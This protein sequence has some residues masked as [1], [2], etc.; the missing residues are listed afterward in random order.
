VREGPP[1]GSGRDTWAVSATESSV[2]RIDAH[3][4]LWPREV[5]DAMERRAEPPYVRDGVMHVSGRPPYRV[6][7]GEHDLAERVARLDRDGID[8]ALVS[9]PPTDFPD[10]PAVVDAWHAGIARMCEAAGHRFLPLAMGTCLP[11]FAGATVAAGA[12]LDDGADRL[13]G[14][15]E[16]AGQILF[17][18][19]GPPAPAPDW[20]PHWWPQLLDYTAQMQAAYAAWLARHAARHP[21]LRVL[22]AILAG[23][24]PFQ[25]ERFMARGA[26]EAS[27]VPPNV[28]LDT[29]SYGPRAI[30][31]ALA[32]V[33]RDAVVYGSDEPVL[34]GRPGL[35]A[36]DALGDA[37]RRNALEGAPA[38]LLDRPRG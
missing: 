34:D 33:G 20:A 35:A 25:F 11:G 14:A 38:R 4:H 19:P 22:F 26:P 8:V 31:L 30:A 36:L 18:H 21:D 13:L 24:A 29:A 10:D 2:R 1:A 32:A 9:L 3:Q 27:L 15:L 37:A 12:L 6:P 28:F 17:I 23:G 16:G 5:L 7:A